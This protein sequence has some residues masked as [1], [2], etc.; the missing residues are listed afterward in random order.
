MLLACGVKLAAAP[1]A[2]APNEGLALERKP[3]T[4][5][6]RIAWWGHPDTAYFVQV[7]SNLR[8][9]SYDSKIFLGKAEVVSHELTVDPVKRRFVRLRYRR[10]AGGDPASADYDGDSISNGDELASGTDPFLVDSDEDGVPDNAETDA[11]ASSTA[12]NEGLRI[13][14]NP[15][16]GNVVLRWWGREGRAYCVQRSEDLAKWE[17]FPTIETG[18]DRTIRWVFGPDDLASKFFIRLVHAESTSTSP[19]TADFDGDGVVNL[20]E[21]QRGQDPFKADSDGDGHPDTGAEQ[22]LVRIFSRQVPDQFLKNGQMLANVPVGSAGVVLESGATGQA[23]AGEFL[24]GSA[25]V[26]ARRGLLGPAS[27]GFSSRALTASLKIGPAASAYTVMGFTPANTG[28]NGLWGSGGM[29]MIFEKSADGH[30]SRLATMAGSG[31]VFSEMNRVIESGQLY[32]TMVRREDDGFSSWIQG[33]MFGKTGAGVDAA[34]WFPVGRWRGVNPSGLQQAGLTHAPGGPTVQ[35]EFGDLREPV[36]DASNALLDYERNKL[37]LHVPSLLKLPGGGLL[38]AWQNATGHESTDCVLKMAR[39]NIRGVWGPA[40]VILASGVDGTSNNGPVL[41]RAGNQIWLTYQSVSKGVYT[42]RK[43]VVHVESDAISLSPPVTLFNQGLL[44][45]HALTL[46]SGRVVVCWHTQQSSWK[47]RISYSD[48]NGGT[49]K[50]AAVPEFPHRA[51]EGFALIESDGTLASY[52]RTDQLAIYRSTSADGGITWTDLVP[53]TIPCANM[54]AQGLLGSRA[55][56]YKRPSDGKLV[57]VGN[58]S[59]TQR[60]KLTAWLVNNGVV[61]GKQSLLAWALPPNRA[62]GL[63]YPDVVVHPDDSMTVI[64]SRW[65][66][67][68]LG[69]TELHSAI[70][71]FRVDAAFE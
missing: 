64:F 67:G 35:S 71:T 45:N 7:S 6:W 19:E 30:S 68:G 61:E 24:W 23:L 12:P 44:I 4:A 58:D 48:D 28:L 56:G 55:S 60:E 13:V 43:R 37:G 10:E 50:T 38:A 32:R 8:D 40:T 29:S 15:V 41:H 21:L 14:R 53:T 51:G 54:L 31:L 59:T 47:N 9:W 20:V 2:A 49:W 27:A 1:T 65:Q 3:G 39:R 62:E 25:A 69:S 52:W 26:N 16:S 66:G 5:G 57:I 36:M 11:P 17:Y 34:A 22:T 70:H 63:Q 42:V 46:P 18:Y 33:G